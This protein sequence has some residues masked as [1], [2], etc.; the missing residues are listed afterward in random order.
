MDAFDIAL[1]IALM[2]EEIDGYMQPLYYASKALTQTKR[3][4][5]STTREA[6]GMI[7]VMY[8]FRHYVLGSTFVFHVDQ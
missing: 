1:G 6:L 3:N 5:N 4:Y 8:K 7:Y 2:P